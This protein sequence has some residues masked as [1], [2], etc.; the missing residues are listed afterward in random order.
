MKF[1]RLGT[2]AREAL[3]AEGSGHDWDH[4]LR[5]LRQACRLGRLCGAAADVVVAAALLH[6]IGRP[7]ELADRGRSD[8]A[9]VGAALAE[10][11]LTKEG[12]GDEAFRH[13]VAACIRTHRYRS[14]GA[15]RP[16]TVE[17]QVL[18]DADKLDALGAI[19]LARALH[20]AGM[21]G[22]RIHNT[23]AEALAG[24][25]Y[26]RED[27]AYREFLVKLRHLPEK[28]LTAPG[29]ALADERLAFMERFF[30]ELTRECYGA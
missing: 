23:A 7:Q 22:A 13:H 19:G 17:A 12:L 21:T 3:Q 27:S 2:I 10:E 24:E 1:A 4:T 18:F 28:M 16:A 29:R 11:I 6:D 5:V 26:G 30:D 14:R 8:H 15:G 25:S 9:A 20:F